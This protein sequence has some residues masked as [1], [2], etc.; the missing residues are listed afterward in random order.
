MVRKEGVC[1]VNI[2][3]EERF[4][5]L[6]LSLFLVEDYS[7]LMSTVSLIVRINLCLKFLLT[8]VR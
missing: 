2:H 4:F 6:S 7:L 3:F 5:F 8:C 1:K